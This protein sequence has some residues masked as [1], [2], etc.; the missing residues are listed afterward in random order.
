[1]EFLASSDY[2]NSVSF[3]IQLR[4]ENP[5]RVGIVTCRKDSNCFTHLTPTNKTTAKKAGAL[6]GLGSDTILA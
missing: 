6:V 2:F 3:L 5:S 4:T 1:M